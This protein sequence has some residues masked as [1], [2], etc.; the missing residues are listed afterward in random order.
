MSVLRPAAI[1]PA[2]NELAISWSDGVEQ[3]LPMETLRRA[4]PCA[5]CR[6]EPDVMGRGEEPVRNYKTG[7]FEMKSYDFVGNYALL[8]R[9]ADGHNSGIYSYTL[10]RNLPG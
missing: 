5:V 9:W 8:F 10:L 7:S 1:A 2:G 6:G 4:C 3:Y